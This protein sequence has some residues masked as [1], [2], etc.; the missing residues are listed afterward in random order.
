VRR[1]VFAWFSEHPKFQVLL[2]VQWRGRAV[3][4]AL[5]QASWLDG[6]TI[7]NDHTP[8]AAMVGNCRVAVTKFA[9]GAWTGGAAMLAEAIHSLVD[10][11]NQLLLLHGLRQAERQPT[12]ERPLDYGREPHDLRDRR[13]R[14]AAGGTGARGVPGSRGA[15]HKAA[16]TRTL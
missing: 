3:W 14:S 1:R 7:A 11:A 15:L 8:Y 12:P 9:A 10:T 16:D 13:S 6:A 5:E 2:R 4:D